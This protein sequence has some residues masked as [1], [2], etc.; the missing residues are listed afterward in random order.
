MTAIFYMSSLADVALPS[1][2]SDISAHS[3]TYFGLGVTV[4]RALAGGLPRPIGA[5]VA[6]AGIAITVAY[7]A[8][9]EFHQAFVPGRTMELRDLIADATGALVG[10]AVCWA[11]GIIASADAH[12]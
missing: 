12:S 1:G 11:W 4:I 3:I 7:G 8:S 5:G 6:V 2:V 9:D 10:A